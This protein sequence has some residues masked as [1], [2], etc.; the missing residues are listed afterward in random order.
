MNR[1]SISGRAVIATVLA[2]SI[3]SSGSHAAIIAE[4]D[5]GAGAPVNPTMQAWTATDVIEEGDPTPPLATEINTS[6]DGSL[7]NVG[8]GSTGWIVRDYLDG[9]A[10]GLDDRPEYAQALTATD[11]SAMQA[12][13]WKYTATFKMDSVVYT[14]EMRVL[15]LDQ[16]GGQYL[17]FD[18]KVTALYVGDE[19]S[20]LGLKMQLEDGAGT[21]TSIVFDAGV[22]AAQFNTVVLTDTNGDGD[23]TM[24]VNGTLLWNH[25]DSTYMFDSTPNDNGVPGDDV[26]VLGA[27]STGG[28]GGGIEYDLLRLEVIPEPGGAAI[29]LLGAVLGAMTRRRND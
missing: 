3:S 14:Q 27:N 15:S 18:I 2:L 11:F 1:L 7:A 29:A 12:S 21:G 5:S 6:G 22:P 20:N 4:Y 13:G 19:T 26:I 28:D 16:G 9:Q 23:F 25:I 17:P 8:A 10:D 24:T